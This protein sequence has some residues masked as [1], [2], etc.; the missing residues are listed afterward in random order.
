MANLSFYAQEIDD[1]LG[2]ADKATAA[3]ALTS[4]DTLAGLGD[5]LYTATAEVASAISDS[6][7][8]VAFTLRVLADMY[9]LILADGSDTYTGAPG[10]WHK[11]SSGEDTTARAAIAEHIAGKSNPH[12]VTKEQV[13]LGNV[14]NTA[15]ID[16]PV[17][18]AVSAALSDKVD[19]VTGKG[20]STNDFTN[21]E[22]TK[23]D[24][25][26]ADT[27]NPH[28]VTKEQ[29]GLGNVDNTSDAD[30][31]ISAAARAVFAELTEEISTKA[32]INQLHELLPSMSA[33][34]TITRYVDSLS[35]GKYT[36][37]I[38]SANKPSDSPVTD[39]AFVD[40]YV[41]SQN[42]AFVRLFPT[43]QALAG[44]VFQLNK[45]AGTWRAWYKFTGEQVSALQA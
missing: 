23:L 11:S 33:D 30:K 16:K 1:I 26:V 10:V 2:R 22:K 7:V 43:G 27:S 40:I 38:I 19:K 9:I 41:Y 18:T 3:T 17:S 20:L 14:D 32:N 31:P 24:S 25:H 5:G 42:T 12:E 15:D 36:T 34:T 4:T 8:S 44:Q 29:V 28:Q 37:M 35:R 6:P 21:A 39:N 45:V 13:G